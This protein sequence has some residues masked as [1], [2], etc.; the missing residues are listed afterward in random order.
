[1][2][3]QFSKGAGENNCTY[4]FTQVQKDALKKCRLV[5]PVVGKSHGLKIPDNFNIV[6]STW[7]VLKA[8][9]MVERGEF[10]HDIFQKYYPFKDSYGECPKDLPEPLKMAGLSIAR[11]KELANVVHMDDPMDMPLYV[12]KW[13]THPMYGQNVNVE[14]HTD[15]YV[16]FLET[17]PYLNEDMADGIKKS[18][19]RIWEVKYFFGLARPEE[20]FEKIT[21]IK[22]ALMTA[23]KEGSPNHPSTGQG[24]MAAGEGGVSVIIKN[25]RENMTYEQVKVCLDTLYFWGM[26]RLLAGVHHGIDGIM[27]LV[28]SPYMRKEFLDKKV[29][30]MYMQ[31]AA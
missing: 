3:I 26:F 12:K 22:G 28:A 9:Q 19:D 20:V 6:E 1:M 10:P 18:I 29:V 15:Q 7:E 30:D 31:K 24:H 25:C 5:N 21:G 8:R 27:S 4:P 2:D 11:P 13:L 23:Y 17:V 16:N 14:A